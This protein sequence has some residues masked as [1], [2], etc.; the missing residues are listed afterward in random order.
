M[1]SK[2]RQRSSSRAVRPRPRLG[3]SMRQ[4]TIYMHVDQFEALHEIN[5]REKVPMAEIVRMGIDY[6][7]GW[8]EDRRKLLESVDS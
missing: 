2:R 4:M 6:A 1:S 3:P 5:D 8:Y 7:I